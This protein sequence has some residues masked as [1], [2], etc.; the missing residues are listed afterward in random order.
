M[1]TRKP[2]LFLLGCALLWIGAP[3]N[4]SATTV[5]VQLTAVNGVSKD[6]VY[7]DPYY[8]TIH[9]MPATLICDDFNHET[10]IGETWT[11]TVST[12]FDLGGARFQQNSQAQTLRD[13]E[14]V[15]YLYNQLLANP[16]E[17]SDISFALW[18][19]FTP[20]VEN[21]SGFTSGA[22][23]WITQAQNQTFY[24]G[25]FSNFEILTPTNG[26]PGSPQEFLSETPEP[27]D[28]LLLVSGLA[29]LALIGKK[30]LFA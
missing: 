5:T 7:V 25:E 30:R 16:S 29:V 27:A 15:A 13:Y 19:I 3:T 21:L 24:T 6:G 20:S 2:I 17:Y 10:S 14:E 23:N 11:A 18:S 4:S 28:A 26:G 1:K 12:F 8:G 9:G 22:Q